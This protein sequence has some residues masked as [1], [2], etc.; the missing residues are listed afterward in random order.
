MSK[1]KEMLKGVGRIF[2]LFPETKLEDLFPNYS[3]S[4]TTAQQ[5]ALTIKSDWE[6]VANDIKYAFRKVAEEYK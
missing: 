1:L 5:D 2:V 3:P 4:I 6:V